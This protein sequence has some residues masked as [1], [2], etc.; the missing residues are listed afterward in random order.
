MGN[1]K[2]AQVKKKG[3]LVLQVPLKGPD[4]R[5]SDSFVQQNTVIVKNGTKT[6]AKPI[7]TGPFKFK[8][9]ESAC[10]ACACATPTTGRTASR[11]STSGR[12]SRSTTIRRA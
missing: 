11:T 6:F 2:L 5:L 9:F 10:A 7:G 8:S 4:A 1:V 12:T 3:P